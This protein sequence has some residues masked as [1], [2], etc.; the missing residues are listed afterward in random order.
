LSRALPVQK[1]EIEGKEDELV[2]PA[3]IHCRL[4]PAEHWYAKGN[5][6]AAHARAAVRSLACQEMDRDRYGRMI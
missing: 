4:E 1:Q 5:L 3:F 2:C 6:R